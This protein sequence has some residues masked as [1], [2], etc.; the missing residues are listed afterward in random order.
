MRGAGG[1]GEGLGGEALLEVPEGELVEGGGENVQ[2]R[3]IVGDFGVERSDDAEGE[4][5]LVAEVGL[6]H[7]GR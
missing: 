3:G 4:A 1:G 7:R 6:H 2:T 5:R